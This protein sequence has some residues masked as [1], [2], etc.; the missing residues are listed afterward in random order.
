MNKKKEI[1]I[2]PSIGVARLGNSPEGKL[3][4]PNKTGGLPHAFKVSESEEYKDF[5]SLTN[6]LDNYDSINQNDKDPVSFKD[7]LGRVKRQGQPF[8][9]YD[10]KGEIFF[11]RKVESKKKD[12]GDIEYIEDIESIEWTVH[13]VNK[14]AEW[15]NFDELK[16][17]LLYKYNGENDNEHGIEPGDN[18]YEAWERRIGITKR[19]I[20]VGKVCITEACNAKLNLGESC[21]DESKLYFINCPDIT[22]YHNK[23]VY[24][25]DNEF[26]EK[27]DDKEVLIIKNIYNDE[28]F[29]NRPILL[30][31]IVDIGLSSLVKDKRKDLCI[32]F[33]P[34]RI[35]KSKKNV[36]PSEATF[37]AENI[38]SG[39]DAKLPPKEVKYG[40]AIEKLGDIKTDD[41]GRLIVFGGRGYTG[42]DT[43]LKG[44]GGG[45]AW[46]DD[47]SDGIVLCKVTYTNGTS[48]DAHAWCIV[49]SPD[50]APE[51]VN[52][53]TLADSIFDVY[54][55]NY[56]LYKVLHDGKSF[57]KNFIAEY[58][59]DIKPIFDRMKAYKWLANVQPMTSFADQDFNELNEN[60]DSAKIKRKKIYQYFRGIDP[61]TREPI[62]NASPFVY[63]KAEYDNIDQKDLIKKEHEMRNEH[64]QTKYPQEYLFYKQ[65]ENL[66]NDDGIEKVEIGNLFP[67][68]PLNSGSNSVRNENPL[69][70]MAL[71]ETQMFLL[72]QWANGKFNTNPNAKW[73]GINPIDIASLGNCIGLPMSPGIEVTWSMHH[74]NIYDSEKPF[75]IKINEDLINKYDEIKNDINIDYKGEKISLLSINRDECDVKNT[76]C[77]PGDLTKRMA[78]PWQ[79]DFLNCSV[80]EVNFSDPTRVKDYIYDQYDTKN[81]D[82]EKS[83]AGI[84]LKLKSED[85]LDINRNPTPPTYYAHWWPASSPWD[86]LVGDFTKEAQAI[87]GGIQS[88]R[89]M[90]YQRGINSYNQMVEFWD[91]LSFIRNVNYKNE[92]FPYFVEM[93]RNHEFFNSSNVD[94]FL[95]SDN[96]LD[97]EVK[98][99]IFYIDFEK[100]NEKRYEQYNDEILII[101]DNNSGSEITQSN[102]DVS[103]KIIELI[104]KIS[105]NSFNS[106]SS[107][108][109]TFRNRR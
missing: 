85:Q 52:I 64:P 17:N 30:N 79:A 59:R 51:I 54:V 25:K 19:N 57:N 67:L 32:D 37:S 9:V 62:K 31:E 20:E 86:T 11:G 91:T 61:F 7:E 73:N 58:Y 76:G 96:N 108:S 55:R 2:H 97:C 50:F 103:S 70:F 28:D 22:E 63:S 53:T 38:P 105:F 42:G 78:C 81:Y 1:K 77:E 109:T 10:E 23:Q 99:P 24:L 60:T 33:G 36:I 82:I 95:I 72:E 12:N 65:N 88:G 45:D 94:T 68:M 69:K 6:V 48:C 3:L 40:H 56:N 15:Y 49:G 34:R 18:S 35:G 89:Q 16:G 75:T 90:N 46:H 39:Y 83:Q 92:G 84:E 102:S 5:D 80:Q 26:Y 107:N 87:N 41:K 98:T 104:D 43:D 74:P 27:V 71:T 47:V 8:R 21:P 13:L 106:F 101:N 44:F 93:E 100:A 66:R 14:K 4:V 29:L